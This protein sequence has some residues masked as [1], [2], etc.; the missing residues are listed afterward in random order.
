MI[1]V[2]PEIAIGDDELLVTFVLAAGPGG[3]NVNKVATS[4]QLRFDAAGSPS[5]PEPVK[6]RLLALAG[7]RATREGV[8]IIQAR[9]YRSQPR[10]RADAEE[11]MLA[12]I[13]RAAARPKT[14]H[15]TRPTAASRR[16]RLE[17][18][19]RHSLTKARRRRPNG[20]A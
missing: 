6:R 10:N 18:K 15:P 16:K 14:R 5:L 8:I 7:R 4:V 13:R 19:R 17:D 2:T 1:Q 9:R 11:R 12:L 3:Q 20:E